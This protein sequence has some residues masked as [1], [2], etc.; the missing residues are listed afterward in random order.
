MLKSKAYH[1]MKLFEKS[2]EVILKMFADSDNI[3]PIPI[4]ASSLRILIKN[5]IKIYDL[6][7]R[8]LI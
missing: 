1:K 8:D 3:I 7:S 6:D 5:K 2:E 4:K